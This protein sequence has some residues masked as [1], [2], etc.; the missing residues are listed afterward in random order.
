MLKRHSSSLVFLLLAAFSLL[1]GTG[2]TRTFST[3]V[4][5]EQKVNEFEGNFNVT[6]SDDDQFG[7]SVTDIGDLE[8]DG[9]TDL[10]IG[11]PL[12][13]TFEH[14]EDVY[15]PVFKPVSTGGDS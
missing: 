15:L 14:Y 3:E 10:A 1:M 11:M 12:E 4:G 13:V 5:S 6:L 8:S 7:R 2:C 9:V